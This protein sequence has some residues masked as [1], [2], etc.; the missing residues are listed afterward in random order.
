MAYVL[1]N[2]HT[3]ITK[4]PNGKFAT[5]Y[6]SSLASQYDAE[7]KA[8]NVLNCLPR[9]YKEAG[10]LPKKIEV[11]EASAQLKEIVAPAQ[12]ERKRFDPVSY[13]VEDSEWMTDF[14]KS[15][16]IVD[17]TLSSLK[18]MYANLY[19]DLTRATDE[20]AVGNSD[21]DL[22]QLGSGGDSLRGCSAGS[23]GACSGGR[24]AAG[25]QGSGSSGHAGNFQKITTSD[26]RHF[27]FPLYFYK[28]VFVRC[29]TIRT[30]CTGSKIK[31]ASVLSGHTP[32]RT[33]A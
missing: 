27:V 10:Y 12:P 2:G 33:K 6:D 5:T 29:G 9:T 21:L 32:T 25:G 14:K 28:N 23:G 8:W 4:K 15:L 26:L 1:T 19:S 16:K 3:Y 24:A 20:R 18:P 17:K 7:S 30:L 31:N 11:K 22:V 13:P